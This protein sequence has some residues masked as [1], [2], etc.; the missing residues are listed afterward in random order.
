MTARIVT[1]L[2]AGMALASLAATQ[3]PP[4]EAAYRALRFNELDLAV[5]LFRAAI[6]LEPDK[7]GL[8]KDFA[9]T[10]LKTGEREEARDEFAAA[11]QLEPDNERVALEYAYLCYETRMPVAARRIFARLRSSPDPSI[12]AAAAQAFENIDR[13]LREGLERWKAALAADPGQWS[14][15]DELA[16]LAEQRDELDLAAAHYREAWNLRPAERRLMLD[17]ARVLAERGQARESVAVLLAASRGPQPRVAESARERLPNRYPY[18]YE[19]EDALAV[20][21][22]NVE[23]RREYAYLLLAM[24]NEREATA[25]LRRLVRT[26]PADAGA[27][28]Q[29]D[30]LQPGAKQMGLRSL[31]KSYLNDALR[32]LS[33][34]HEENPGDEEVWLKL[35]WTYNMMK[36]DDLAMQWFN[37]ARRSPAP[38]IAGEAARAYRNL[39]A[40]HARFR[41]SV[42]AQPFFSSRWSSGLLF[43]QSR[44]EIRLGRTP[45]RPYLSM[46]FIG[47]TQGRPNRGPAGALSPGF[48]SDTSVILAAGLGA[49]FRRFYVWG[50]AGQSIAYIVHDDGRR[51]RPDYRGGVS[52]LKGWGAVAGTGRQGWFAEQGADAVFVSRFQNNVFTYLQTRAGYS[53]AIEEKGFVL[54]ALWHWNLTTDTK[55]VWW[56]NFAETGPGIRVRWNSLPPGL[57]IT[58]ELLR[59]AHL[60]NTANP[61]GP[62]YWDYRAGV[63]YAFAR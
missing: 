17:L 42:W 5:A 55:R 48:L 19:F 16:R 13:P 7:A 2:V 22:A 53:V 58:T 21:P 63:W 9:Y 32:Y 27:R 14:G 57:W 60:V 1:A 61:R 56:G 29:L 10:L 12:R 8:R 31:E 41:T 44:T 54:Q 20:E 33:A 36:R 6:R 59:G 40:S 24:G 28:A 30:A 35:G 39:R 45:L 34:A 51:T 26:A 18:P 43:G 47:D 38:Q 23:L 50:E 11:L 52:W 3:E 4:G 46:R 25:Q 15:H 37:R 49:Q 62:N